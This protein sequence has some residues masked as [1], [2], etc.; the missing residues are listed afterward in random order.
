MMHRDVL[1]CDGVDHLAGAGH[2]DPSH[3]GRV[4]R[5][6]QQPGKVDDRVSPAQRGTEV[7]LGDVEGV[8]LDVAV[9]RGATGDADHRRDL[10]SG[11][12]LRQELRPDIAGRA[13]DDDA[14]GAPVPLVHGTMPVAP[15]GAAPQ[16][17]R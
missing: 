17:R 10:G 15:V 14:H 1:G 5:R 9:R 4:V 13:C 11:Q 2:V 12:E 3:L 16:A 8:P 7:V 6:L